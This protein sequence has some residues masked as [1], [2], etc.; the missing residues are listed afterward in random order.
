MAQ[1][2]F[3]D[4]AWEFCRDHGLSHA[5]ADDL[6]DRVYGWICSIEPPAL[7]LSEAGGDDSPT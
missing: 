6:Y 4:V 7:D 3:H 5:A 2:D 1:T